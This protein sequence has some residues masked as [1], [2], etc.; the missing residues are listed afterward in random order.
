VEKDNPKSFINDVLNKKRVN[1]KSIVRISNNMTSLRDI[2]ED[3][4]SSNESRA[5]V[6]FDHMHYF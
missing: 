5:L 2:I 1:L 4:R 6:D 3:P